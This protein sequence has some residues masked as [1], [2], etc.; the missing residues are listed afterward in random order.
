MGSVLKKIKRTIA[1]KSGIPSRRKLRTIVS[2]AKKTLPKVPKN[3]RIRE[4]KA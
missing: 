4:T 2:A 3:T 1:L